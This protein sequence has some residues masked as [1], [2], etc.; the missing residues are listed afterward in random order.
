MSR[1]FS[2]LSCASKKNPIQE[3]VIP[4]PQKSGKIIEWKDTKPFTVPFNK[5]QVI[6]VYDGD[7]ITIASTMPFNDSSIYRFSVR[8]NGIDCPEIK[9][10]NVEEKTVAKYAQEELSRLI[11]H[12]EVTLKNM[13]TEK[14]GRILAEVYLGDLH[15]NAYMVEK[16]LA[17]PYDGGKKGVPTSWLN[18]YLT[19]EM[20]MKGEMNMN[21]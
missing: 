10:Q 7:T 2:Y 1:F 11:L 15:I 8:L 6:K 5:A 17:V 18:Y 12:K 19:G 14:Y 9:T 4:E 13:N 3:N 16:R 20:N 21:V